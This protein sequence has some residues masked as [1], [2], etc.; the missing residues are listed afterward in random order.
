MKSPF[1]ID[2]AA[3]EPFYDQTIAVSGKLQSSP[4]KA[5]ILD[6]DLDD[7]LSDMSQSADRRRVF[8]MIPKYGDKGWNGETPPKLG[9]TLTV[10][11]WGG[12]QLGKDEFA[13]E[14]VQ[15][16]SDSWKLTARE[17]KR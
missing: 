14:L 7:P 17:V 10:I 12:M 5:C 9:D 3:F 13:I 16:Y 11:S 8:V 1:D 15:D 6:A 4:L 2:G